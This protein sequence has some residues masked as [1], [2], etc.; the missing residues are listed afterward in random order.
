MKINQESITCK[1]AHST[2]SVP[3][4]TTAVSLKEKKNKTKQTNNNKKKNT[5]QR[6]RG[7]TRKGESTALEEGA[8]RWLIQW[9]NDCGGA[10]RSP[11]LWVGENMFKSSSV[12]G[13]GTG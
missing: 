1:R 11:V 9:L 6:E 3:D 2:G 4:S 8:A 5:P 10:R 13:G 7:R 12:G